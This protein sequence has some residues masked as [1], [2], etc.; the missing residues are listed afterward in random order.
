MLT[1]TATDL[2]K[3]FQ[4]PTQM[5]RG[6]SSSPRQ[7]K[8]MDMDVDN[9]SSEGKSD[10]KVIIVNNLT[11]NVVEAHLKMIFG[12]YGEVVKVDLPLY[13]NCALTNFFRN[14]SGST[15]FPLE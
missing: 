11:R 8:G 5:S 4:L 6:R 12:S 1:N 2:A 13:G 9:R 7:S 3:N 14:F 10:S 15:H